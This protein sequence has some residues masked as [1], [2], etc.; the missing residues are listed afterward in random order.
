MDA[1]PIDIF[2]AAIG[3]LTAA[4]VLFLAYDVRALNRKFDRLEGTRQRG[5][6][7]AE[8]ARERTR[9]PRDPVGRQ[10]GRSSAAGDPVHQLIDG[11]DPQLA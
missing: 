5:G 2:T 1:T 7:S 4:G 6:N 10:A 3:T 11:G 9:A 8:R